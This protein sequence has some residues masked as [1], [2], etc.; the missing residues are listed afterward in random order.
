MAPRWREPILSESILPPSPQP[1]LDPPKQ[2]P[3]ATV[4]TTLPKNNPWLSGTFYLLAVVVV[5]I[6][7]AF[8]AVRASIEEGRLRQIETA[9]TGA[10]GP[11][12]SRHVA[13]YQPDQF[14]AHLKSLPLSVRPLSPQTEIRRGYK[15]KRQFMQLAPEERKAREEAAIKTISDAMRK[16]ST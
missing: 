8:L 13:C 4:G 14:I 7:F 9:V 11:E 6:L 15:V 2:Q 1:A 5:T 16:K 12:S 3:T 10:L